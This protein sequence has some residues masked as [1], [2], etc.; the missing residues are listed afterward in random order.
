M[1]II[2]PE[3]RVPASQLDERVMLR[4]ERCARICYKSEDKMDDE[5]SQSFLQRI[6]N[7]GHESVIEHEKV[8]ALFIIDR[9]ISHELVR[10]RIGSYSQ[11]ST[12]YCNYGKDRFGRE[13]SVIKP[14]FYIP[15]TETHALW[16]ESCLLAEK[17]YLDLLDKGSTPQEARSILPTCLKTEI[18]VTYNI[19]EWRHFF[20]MRCSTA[21]H[22]QMRQVAI[23]LL[24]LFQDKF[25]ALF[26]KVAYDT[27]FPVEH[28]AEVLI[29]DDLFN[30]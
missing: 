7:S 14:Y 19:R 28:Y 3:I 4:L 1:L 30:I 5:Y 9:G 11:E 17:N 12:R 27:A 22:P 16:E 23:P 24:L 6:V 13:I 29:S 20:Y 8:T 25:K 2:P 21:A 18:A 10:H 26:G 15:G